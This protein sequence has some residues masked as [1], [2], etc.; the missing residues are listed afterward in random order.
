MAEQSNKK[1]S[2][3]R[4]ENRV[5]VELKI[6]RSST[7][8]AIGRLQLAN[9]LTATK[10][11]PKNLWLGP[12][13]WLLISDMEAPE[14]IIKNCSDALAD[15]LHNAVDY[16]SGLAIFRISGAGARELLAT[17]ASL[18]FRQNQFSVGACCRTRFAMISAIIVA[19][20]GDQFD[21]YV[22]RSYEA[23]VEDWLLDSISIAVMAA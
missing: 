7:D 19:E 14:A 1:V 20:E 6:S 8:D 5:M 23:Y 4:V 11:E 16:S 3:E 18:D 21:I 10:A 17:G 2:V 15:V 13:Q 22:D 12:D 9:P